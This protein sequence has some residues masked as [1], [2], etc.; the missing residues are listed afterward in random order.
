M[1]VS[2]KTILRY[3]LLTVTTGLAVLVVILVN[4]YEP[5]RLQVYFFDV[6]QG[7]SI[8]IRTPDRHTILVDGGPNQNVVEKISS[9]L[10][11]YD[12][13]I[14]L[15]V[16][17]HPHADHVNGLVAVLARY[18][19]SRVLYTGVSYHSAMYQSWRDAIAVERSVVTVADHVGDMDV[20]RQTKI[21]ILYP[22][23]SLNGKTVGNL[24]NSSIVFRLSYNGFTALLAGDQEREEDLVGEG[25]IKPATIL[26]VGHHGSRNGSDPSF[27]SAVH[28]ALAIISDGA[29]NR[30]GHP[31]SETL[32]NL[33]AINTRILRTD[34]DGDIIIESDGRQ[35]W[36]T[37]H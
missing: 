31:H 21:T 7:D 29:H 6:G 37:P 34:V 25:L 19:V 20:G 2:I 22:G 17:T 16:L 36:V 28:P 5:H 26:K 9:V 12:R 30:Y 15:M 3:Y 1:N 23:E 13:T 18:K 11:W 27:L 24:N 35:W 33:A 32:K 10:P 14:D 8:L 4:A